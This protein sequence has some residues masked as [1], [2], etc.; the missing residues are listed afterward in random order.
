[1]AELLPNIDPSSDSSLVDRFRNGDDKAADELYTKYSQRLRAFVEAQTSQKL[2]RHVE[3]DDVMQVVFFQFFQMVLKDRYTPPPNDDNWNLFLVLALNHIR[4]RARF[5]ARQKRNSTLE[6][7]LGHHS[8]SLSER[9]FVELRITVEDLLDQ[10]SECQRDI[11]GMRIIGFELQEIA[12]AT[13][14]ST[15]T[16]KRVLRRFRD[17][18]RLEVTF[19]D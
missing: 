14:V 7:P 17:R 12:T 8:D 9:S 13:Q 19:E 16:I 15:R 3:C 18:L 2:K 6:R 1:M 5:Y 10:L 4:Q 11:I